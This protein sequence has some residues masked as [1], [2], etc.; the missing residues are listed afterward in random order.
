M[1]MVRKSKTDS[2][3]TVDRRAADRRLKLERRTD[4][5]KSGFQGQELRTSSR[6]KVE[7]RRQID[8]TTCERDYNDEEIEFTDDDGKARK[9]IKEIQREK[10]I[11]VR[12]ALDMV[13]LAYHGEY[14][15][16]VLFSQDRDLTKAVKTLHKIREE[17][18]RW[19]IIE[20]AFCYSTD[21][22]GGCKIGIMK[23]IPWFHI[24]REIYDACIDP[25]YY[26]PPPLPKPDKL[27]DE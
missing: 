23:D 17:L 11:D 21:L 9:L 16:A 6:R 20:N 1:K 22:P 13:D 3:L 12:I 8:P 10:G 25:N 2:A 15:I 4:E 24:T 18:G 19:I 14:D 5:E 27:F 7:R 26:R